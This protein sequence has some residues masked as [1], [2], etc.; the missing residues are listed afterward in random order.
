MFNLRKSLTVGVMALTVFV[1]SGMASLVSAASAQPGD[2]VK[3]AGAKTVYYL[4]SDS[5]LYNIPNEG[6]YFSWY[7]DWSGVI[8]ISVNDLNSY[9]N[10]IP[11]GFVTMRPGTNLVQRDVTTDSTVY[12]VEPN[13][14]LRPIT[15]AN[16]IALYGSNWAKKVTKVSD[17]N[18]VSYHVSTAL[19]TNQYPIGTLLKK[20]TGPDVFYF[21]GT[22]YR[23]VASEAAFNAN[24]FNAKY[25]VKTSM[26]FTAGGNDITGMESALINAAQNGGTIVTPPVVTGSGLTVSLNANTPAAVSVPQ[27][28]ARVPMAKL[29]LTAA[30]DGAIT[31]NS[32]TVKRIGLSTYSNIDKV[33]AEKDGVIVASKK[34]MNSNDESILTFSPAFTVPAGTTVALDLIASLTGSNAGNIGLSVA[35][36]SSVSAT[37][38][39]VA[40]SFP[41]NGNLMSPTSYAVEDVKIDNYLVATSSV[42]VGDLAVNFG[43]FQL[44]TT[45][46]VVLSSITLKNNGVEDLA[47]VASNLY[48]EQAGNKIS[49]SYSVNGRFVTFYFNAGTE[50]LKDDSSKLFYIKGDVIAKENSGSNSLQFTLNKSTDLVGQEKATGFGFNVKYLNGTW[51]SADNLVLSNVSFDAGAI[52]IT[53]K[54]TSPSDT[55]IVK[56][57]DNVVLLANLRADEA[58]VADGLYITYTGT[59]VNKFEN[60]RVYVNGV[61]LDS[62]DPSTTTL[63]NTLDSTVNLNK[64]DNEVKVMVKAKSDA[65]A[66]A[67]IKFV[68]SGS[69]VFTGQ[70]PEY[71]GS[72]NSVSANEISGTATGATFTVAGAT[73]TAVRNDGYADGKTIVQGGTDVSLGK[74]TL[75]ASNDSV[76]VTS[77]A[78]GANASTTLP[79]SISDMKLFVDGV[80]VGNT[81][82]FNTSGATFSSLNMTIAKDA[83][84]SL[85][86]KGSF[87]S[88]ATGGFKT[89]MT[90]SAQDSRGTAVSGIATPNTALFA[91]SA[92]GGLTIAL[93]GNTPAAGMLASKN[94][95]EQEIAQFK[96]TATDDDAS[97]TELNVI[98]VLSTTSSITSTSAAV[99][100]ADSRIASIMLYD[101]ATLIDSFVPVSGAGKFTITNDKVK[102]LANTNKVLTIKVVLNNI[103]NDATATNQDI[104]LGL[105]TMKFKSSNGTEFTQ[106]TNGA[107]GI[108]ANNFRVRKTIPTVQ[109][110]ALPTSVLT[111]GDTVVSK[112]TVSADSN[113]DVE[114]SK[115]A[116]NVTASASSTFAAVTASTT[117][118]LKVN[119]TYKTITSATYTGGQ[120]VL[121]LANDEVISAGTSKTFEIY[122]A[123]GVSGTGSESITTKIV[124][125]SAYGTTGN[126][127]WSDNASISSA[128]YSNG[129]RVPGLTTNT[130]VLSK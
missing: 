76:K 94:G 100:N 72:D 16:A 59:N 19:P 105:T 39:T 67:T 95:V 8:T 126:F 83:T 120:L 87:D 74:F 28:G 15:T 49:S 6:T 51:V 81:V 69:N 107:N 66:P 34:T 104:H 80:Q 13:G 48:L 64:G 86:L 124:E 78:L 119:G 54:S 47:K 88:S 89:T 70:N 58:I 25:V 109:L 21:D 4:G 24:R 122:A 18:F 114:L 33:W 93:G 111:A 85:E 46:D 55:T 99:A 37:S 103:N 12:A 26:S 92:N 127:V 113:G 73:L 40:G 77:I 108:L 56:G 106:G 35:S 82:D 91:V 2:L 9:G 121:V 79:S 97:L 11:A 22:N 42:K 68:I 98:N 44:N 102:V 14:T 29:N 31:V 7:K 96:L 23:K 53:K 112:F 65:T 84:K 57:S 71:V 62:F 61:L 52:S 60:A 130:Q 115:I 27:N 17:Q 123:T 101:G 1:M 45:K 10:G 36:A 32:I 30:N 118:T 117:N 38:A 5:K 90:I 41:V 110:A 116:I 125:D 50:I 129:Y 75:K 43:Q 128:T 20:T 63:A 3:A